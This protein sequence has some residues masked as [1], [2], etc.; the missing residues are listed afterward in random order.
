MWLRPEERPWLRVY[1]PLVLAFALGS[2]FWLQRLGVND[3]DDAASNE[4]IFA[5]QPI[6]TLGFDV[7]WPDQSPL[8]FVLL[9]FWCRLGESPRVM[10]FLQLALLSLGLVLLHRLAQRLCRPRA[11][12][13]GAVLLATLSPAS[14]WLVRNGRMYTLQLVLFLVAV[15]CL[16]RFQDG[17]RP[18]DLLGFVAASVLGI[19]N[20][21]L[22][23]LI[24]AC[25]ILWLCGELALEANAR[26]TAGHEAAGSPHAFRRLLP[27]A[28]PSG[29]VIGVAAAPQ[30]ARMLAFV[31]EGEHPCDL[32]RRR[33]PDDQ[34]ARQGVR[35]QASEGMRTARRLVLGRAT[36]IRLE[37]ELAAEPENEAGGDEQAEEVVVD[38][39]DGG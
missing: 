36:R 35:Q 38:A 31:Q 24:T 18:R 10:A 32:G 1:F 19:Y 16:V 29:L 4:V 20:H 25:L 2:A 6:A 30:V 22:G 27:Y 14:L 23:L 34:A 11:V 39:E 12:A 7:K 21:F 37:G 17:R 28:L 3:L 5:R 33:H 15:L 8:Y 26:R 9:H 13:D